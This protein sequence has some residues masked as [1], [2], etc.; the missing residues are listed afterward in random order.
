MS[1]VFRENRAAEIFFEI[2]ADNEND[3][4]ESGAD[5]VEYRIVH[6]GLSL[7]AERIELFQTAI[8]ASHAG[9]E[10]E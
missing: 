6:Y 1:F 3:F 10:N 9:G 2:L 7:R 8:A 4:A 5:S